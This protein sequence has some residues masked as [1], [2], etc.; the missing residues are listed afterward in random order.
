MYAEHPRLQASFNSL[1][2]GANDLCAAS[3]SEVY[4]V[5]RHDGRFFVYNSVDPKS[6][7]VPG[8]HVRFAELKS[9]NS[10]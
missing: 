8:P 7:E 9:K 4:L 5:I 10:C 2:Q 3:T 6:Y 1:V